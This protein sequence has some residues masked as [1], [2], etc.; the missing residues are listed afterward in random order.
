MACP[1]LDTVPPSLAEGKEQTPPLLWE[2]VHQQTSNPQGFFIVVTQ[3][4]SQAILDWL[5]AGRFGRMHDAAFGCR[6]RHGGATSHRASHVFHVSIHFSLS[7]GGLASSSVSCSPSRQMLCV[8]GI[9]FSRSI[10]SRGVAASFRRSCQLFSSIF[11]MRINPVEVTQGS[12][13]CR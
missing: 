4:S 13:A 6:T 2:G 12:H 11:V 9:S 5:T 1:A 8:S 7:I 10:N 3:V